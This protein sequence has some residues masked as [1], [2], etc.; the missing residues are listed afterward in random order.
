MNDD[1]QSGL[2]R[3]PGRIPLK[4]CKMRQFFKT[5]SGVLSVIVDYDS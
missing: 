1:M 5:T 2:L 3:N 4:I